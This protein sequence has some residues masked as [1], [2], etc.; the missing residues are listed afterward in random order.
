M[1]LL[2]PH[3]TDKILERDFSS[4]EFQGKTNRASAENDKTI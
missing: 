1:E 3:E 4:K 2:H